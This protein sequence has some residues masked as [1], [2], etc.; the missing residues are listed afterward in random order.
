MEYIADFNYY[1]RAFLKQNQTSLQEVIKKY[2]EE[3][4][5]VDG[6]SYNNISVKLRNN[7][8]SYNQVVELLDI[9]GYEV[10]FKKKDT[11]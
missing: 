8:I 2:E 3:K 6:F 10:V 7:T 11:K 4:G 9:I 1:F 5:R